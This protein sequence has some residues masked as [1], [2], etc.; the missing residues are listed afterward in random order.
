MAWWDTY[1]LTLAAVVMSLMQVNVPAP[2]PELCS[3]RVFSSEW[4][5][6]VP[7]DKVCF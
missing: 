5:N 7:I 3:P 2:I 4:V 6:G 1:Q